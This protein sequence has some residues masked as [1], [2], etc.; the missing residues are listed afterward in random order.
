MPRTVISKAMSEHKGLYA[1]TFIHLH[2][3]GPN[4]YTPLKRARPVKPNIADDLQT[5][6]GRA[7][8]EEIA[9][10]QSWLKP[11]D[12]ERE[13]ERINRQG[14]L[15]EE[16]AMQIDGEGYDI[17]EGL[18]EW[19]V[20][21]QLSDRSG[22]CFD[23]FEANYMTSCAEGHVFCLECARRNAEMTVGSARH[24]VK[25]MDASGCQAE[26]RPID[27]AR[28]LDRKTIALIDKL[29][30][31]EAVRQVRLPAAFAN[32]GLYP[33]VRHLSLLRLW[34]NCRR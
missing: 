3:L 33:R 13:F 32:S 4:D 28:F 7:V 2:G 27:I 6:A 25:C 19:Y 30:S 24:L 22:C 23:E 34:R 26:F 17:H 21:L 20:Q 15:D 12:I 16:M 29:E 14:E 11:S 9:F 1:P 31:A 5:P 10:I 18:L 8:S